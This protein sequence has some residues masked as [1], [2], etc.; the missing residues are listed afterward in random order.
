MKIIATLILLCLALNARSQ[1]QHELNEA[2]YQR[3]KAADK[4]LNGI[5]NAVIKKHKSDAVFTTNLKKA[6]KIWIQFRNAE[7]KAKYPNRK[8]GHYGSIQ[9]ICEYDYLTE[10]TTER[11]HKLKQWLEGV[12]EG[13]ACNGTIP[14]K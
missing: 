10:L 5:Y 8:P 3:Y 13:D 9:P 11:T 6:Q 14:I 4:Q 2:A 12:E 1:T 7:L